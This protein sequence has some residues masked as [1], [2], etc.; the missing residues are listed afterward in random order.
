[1]TKARGKRG[2]DPS[3][4]RAAAERLEVGGWL[5]TEDEDARRGPARN[6]SHV[7]NRIAA[8]K[9]E[10]ARWCVVTDDDGVV[11]IG[12]YEPEFYARVTA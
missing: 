12:R 9:G 4:L 3:A 2:P 10:T 7:L 8:D 5:E 11:W 6:V 1:M